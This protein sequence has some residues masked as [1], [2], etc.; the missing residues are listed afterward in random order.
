MLPEWT[1]ATVDKK[2]SFLVPKSFCGSMKA[3]IHL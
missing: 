1:E 2:V 3:E